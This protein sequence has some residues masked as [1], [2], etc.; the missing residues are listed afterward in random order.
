MKRTAR[1]ASGFATFEGSTSAGDQAGG[2]VQQTPIGKVGRYKITRRI[3]E[4][5][6]G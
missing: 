4:G 3:G 6:M 1:Q 5:G 2:I